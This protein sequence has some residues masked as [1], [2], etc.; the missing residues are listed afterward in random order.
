MQL[1][2]QGYFD[3]DLLKL[4]TEGE[5]A[6]TKELY[7]KYGRSF[8]GKKIIIHEGEQGSDVYLIISGRVVVCEK[9]RKGSYKVLASLGPGEIFGEMA[10]LE[11]NETRSATLI[12]ASPVKLIQLSKDQFGVLF[13]TH[14]RWAFK[15]LS[16]MSGRILNTMRQVSNYYK[17]PGRDAG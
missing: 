1:D 3:L 12:A 11:E 8:E 9:L 17:N 2:N 7:S 15:L 16:A 4:G 13:K 6:I 5:K 10:A 14:S